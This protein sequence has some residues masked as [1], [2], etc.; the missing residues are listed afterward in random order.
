LPET[1]CHALNPQYTCDRALEIAR[2]MTGIREN[3]A[4]LERRAGRILVGALN[5]GAVECGTRLTAA[6]QRRTHAR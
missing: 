6:A 1:A 4:L 3:V 2:K 5:G